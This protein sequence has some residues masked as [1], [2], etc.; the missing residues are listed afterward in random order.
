MKKLIVFVLL[1]LSIFSVS[2][3]AEDASKRIEGLTD[4]VNSLYMR[5]HTEITDEIKE[6]MQQ[7]IIDSIDDRW[8]SWLTITKMLGKANGK[9]DEE[10][11]QEQLGYVTL[12][13]DEAFL[14]TC[15]GTRNYVYEYAKNNSLYYLFTDASYW[16][17]GPYSYSSDYVYFDGGDDCRIDP[18]FYRPTVIREI[19]RDILYK[20]LDEQLTEY[21]ETSVDDIKIFG[22]RE[23]FS[24]LYVRCGDNEYL[25]KLY[26][27]SDASGKSGTGLNQFEHGKIY[28]AKEIMEVMG[29]I[30]PTDEDGGDSDTYLLNGWAKYIGKE[31][32]T[33]ETEAVALCEQGLLR[34]NEK[35]LDLLKPLTR[36]E[37]AAIILRAMGVEETA[38]ETQM[39]TDVSKTHWG[40]NIAAEASERGIINGIGN[41][42][43]AP[44]KTIKA[45]EFATMILR[46]AGETEFDWEQALQILIDRGIITEEDSQ[47]MDLFTRGDMA[48]IIYE[49]KE[50]GLL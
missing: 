41:N 28:T 46:G 23:L 50:N 35:G 24:F 34:G 13:F 22:F 40:Y 19:N 26:A 38:A 12:N 3:Y 15:I 49:V 37:A 45:T 27:D 43:F 31:K 48:K 36:I 44:D 4:K 8:E 17:I 32:P 7:Q 16:K 5:Y 1:A 18:V 10:L 39:F 29:T 11:Y 25:E 14:V 47:T 33:F 9:T 6:D 21:G 2:V 20:R 30:V 42:L